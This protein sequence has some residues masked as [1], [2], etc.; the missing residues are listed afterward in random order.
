[1]NQ[2]PA[3]EARANPRSNMFLAA[4][5]RADDFS[6]PVK[7]R[8]M[9]ANGALVEGAAVPGRGTQVQL[10][11]GSLIVPATVAW[12]AAGRCGLRFG[13]LA[14][15]RDWLAPVSKSAQQQVDD[16]VR[17]IKLGAVP[18][19]RSAVQTRAREPASA[20]LGRDLQSAARLIEEL[21][22]DLSSDE[23]VLARHGDKLQKFDIALQMITV[24]ADALDGGAGG[25]VAERLDNLR[26]S[27]AA[28]LRKSGT[29]GG[30]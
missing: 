4:L 8:N 6:A 15:V 3:V 30:S 11:R 17:L 23:Q 16:A 2:G 29:G 18:M 10:I 14:C 28:A 19:P 26:A 7:V 21:G 9:S 20:E 27:S 24:V 22:D 5:L 25:S 12:S 13:S 1:M